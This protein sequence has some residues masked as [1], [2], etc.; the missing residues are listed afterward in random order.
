M[1]YLAKNRDLLNFMR[2]ESLRVAGCSPEFTLYL[3]RHNI[4]LRTCIAHAGYLNIALVKFLGNDSGEECFR[5]DMD[6]EPAA[7]IEALAFDQDR[8]QFCLDLVAWPYNTPLAFSTAMGVSDGADV[9]GPQNM[10]SRQGEPLTIHRT[11]L[12][13]LQA[14]CAGCVLLKPAAGHWLKRAGGPFIV[15]DVMHGREIRDLLG[16]DARS[17]RILVKN[18]SQRSAA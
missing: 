12:A 6:G 10:V 13:W 5:F 18:H 17:H 15:E 1:T 16:P 8:H 7:V 14:D 4:S 9:L 3:T 2:R 11:P